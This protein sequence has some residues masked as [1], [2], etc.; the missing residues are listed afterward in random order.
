M[1]IY[2]RNKNVAQSSYLS[3]I[4]KIKDKD[5]LA[6]LIVKT[7]PN[8]PKEGIGQNEMNNVQTNGE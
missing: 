7:L 3:R 2:K 6:N 4:D 5:P 1:K 8:N